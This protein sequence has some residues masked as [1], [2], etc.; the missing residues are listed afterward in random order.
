MCR[1]S[2]YFFSL[3]Q[4]SKQS[5]NDPL[6]NK[7]MLK[8]NHKKKKGNGNSKKC[9]FSVQLNKVFRLPKTLFI[10]GVFLLYMPAIGQRYSANQQQVCTI[11]TNTFDEYSLGKSTHLIGTSVASSLPRNYSYGKLNKYINKYIYLNI[12]K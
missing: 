1:L 10:Q 4:E 6:T 7:F 9:L 5:N 8:S 2:K 3:E 12:Y 11:K